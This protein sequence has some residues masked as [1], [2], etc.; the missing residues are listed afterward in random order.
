[1]M[2]TQSR[3]KARLMEQLTDPAR[4]CPT[5]EGRE[6]VFR[7]RKQIPAEP[8]QPADV[9][10]R[11]ACKAC[12]HAWKEEVPVKEAGQ[13]DR[14]REVAPMSASLEQQ[15]NE[16]VLAL[17]TKTGQATGYWPRYFLRKAR[18]VGG[19]RLA[20]DLLQPAK[21]ATG[22]GKLAETN[23][24]EL[25]VEYLALQPKWS[26]LFTEAERQVARSRLEE[27][28]GIDTPGGG[29]N[30][31]LVVYFNN[32]KN[33]EHER[34]FGSGAFYDLNVAGLQASQAVGLQPGRECV[35]VTTAPDNRVTFTWHSFLR[36]RRL[37]ERG[38]Q[39]RTRY[40]V[41]FGDPILAET[42]SKEVA[43]TH[44]RYRYFFNVKGHF[45]QQS[46]ILASVPHAQ[47]PTGPPADSRAIQHFRRQLQ[48]LQQSGRPQAPET[49]RR[50]QRLLQSY[51][52]PSPITRYVKRT[53]GSTCQLC[54][55]PGFLMRNGRR[56]CEVHH[57]FH[58]SKNPPP[59][60]LGPEYLVVLCAT[61][62]RRM[63]Y[64]DIGEPVR[65]AEA[66]RVRVDDKV[67][68]LQV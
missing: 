63:H 51:E 4:C 25:S 23:H 16:E 2:G 41:F 44:P 38:S 34:L 6:D 54:G 49:L 66:W 30:G 65:E 14:H 21:A 52:R 68:L 50:V 58:L 47:R 8:E 67:L 19:Y 13:K 61:C 28:G 40:R 53:R 17:F 35:V 5:C 10:T 62:H 39:D 48:E 59:A 64:A 22:F 18:Q 27:A 20:K 3:E 57:L 15:F 60:C 9:E 56:Y 46:T 29:G 32:C 12:G 45:K 1:M 43:A 37:R 31:D 55:D 36:E 11:C 26:P 7:G 33:R 42:F 24:L